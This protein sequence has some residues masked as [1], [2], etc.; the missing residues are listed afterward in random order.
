MHQHT[1]SKKK[2]NDVMNERRNVMINDCKQECW[3]ERKNYLFVNKSHHALL[4]SVDT[5][6]TK[7]KQ[8]DNDEKWW[9]RKKW[10]SLL[11]C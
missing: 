10:E 1:S 11:N 9:K 4:A 7:M 3:S 8:H 2:M 6:E 5:Y